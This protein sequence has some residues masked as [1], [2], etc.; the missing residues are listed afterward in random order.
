[1]YSF[2]KLLLIAAVGSMATISTAKSSLLSKVH[3]SSTRFKA[4][5]SISFNGPPS[6]T[7][8]SLSQPERVVLDIQ[9]NTRVVGLPLK[10]SS[11]NLVR[12]IRTSEQKNHHGIRLVLDLTR[13]AK[14]QVTAYQ[15]GAIHVLVFELVSRGDINANEVCQLRTPSSLKKGQSKSIHV[16]QKITKP[17]LN[18]PRLV[19]NIN[20][21]LQSHNT[22]DS[23]DLSDRV[24]I[25]IDAGHG[26]QDP[27]AIGVNGLQEKNITIAIANRLHALLHNDLKFYPVL[28]RNGD[29]FISVMGR[30]EMARKK[31]ANMLV[32]IHA[33][34]APNHR[35]KGASVW[36]LSSRRANSEMAS[37]LEQ[38]EKQSELLGGAGEVL[39]NNQSDHY[40]SQA[41]L[42][43]QFC[44]SQRVGYNA[45]MKVLK[46]LKSVGFLHKCRPEHASLGVLR[47][48][49]IP[50]LLVE[51][52]FISNKQEEWL[53]GSSS[54]QDKVARALYKGLCNYF[55]AYPLQVDKRIKNGKESIKEVVKSPNRS[56]APLASPRV[57][58]KTGRWTEQA[59]LIHV[60]KRS[61]TLSGIANK[62]ET[63][64][65]AIRACN[66]L[67]KDRLLVGQHIQIPGFKTGDPVITSS[68]MQS[69]EKNITYKIP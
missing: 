35:A 29:Y 56:N 25:A 2:I 47:S 9:K 11:E 59:E 46:E 44:H 10:F 1:M 53:L 52:G 39:A 50:S 18:K 4:T 30:S 28:T 31:G 67:K 5:V 26:G 24:V 63:T 60:V 64:L 58:I 12:S 42:D 20:T 66:N 62:Y 19:S 21:R 17:L 61:E 41:V 49:D 54:Y 36:V 43:L 33:D 38:C 14:T 32:S 55:L 7:F 3:F 65:A 45:G 13:R 22:C 16:T 69:L 40:L 68:S 34:A 23:K 27:G 48:P 37:W 6:Y 15:R 8:F 57:L 51:T